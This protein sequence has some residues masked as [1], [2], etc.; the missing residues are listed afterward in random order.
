MPWSFGFS[1]LYVSKSGIYIDFST[2]KCL[3]ISTSLHVHA[4]GTCIS[5]CAWISYVY[6]FGILSHLHMPWMFH[7]YFDFFFFDAFEPGSSLL[8]SDFLFS[9]AEVSWPAKTLSSVSGSLFFSTWY[10]HSVISTLWGV[11]DL[12]SAMKNVLEFEEH[13]CR[14][15]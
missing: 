15:Q 12:L 11:Q 1:H 10:V 5:V 9:P 6:M 13:I 8:L 2:Q 14:L 4:L 3:G 7:F